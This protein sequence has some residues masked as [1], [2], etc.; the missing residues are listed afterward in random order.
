MGRE[1]V[2]DGMGN[3]A[4][5][6]CDQYTVAIEPIIHAY[7]LLEETRAPGKERHRRNI[8]TLHSKTQQTR[9]FRLRTFLL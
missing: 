7:G 6:H 9:I 5:S 1:P 3:V 4:P 8:Q 2:H